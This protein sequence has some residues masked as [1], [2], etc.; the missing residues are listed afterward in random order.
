VTHSEVTALM[1]CIQDDSRNTLG[2]G[3][4]IWVVHLSVKSNRAITKTQIQSVYEY[5]AVKNT[6]PTNT[7]SNVAFKTMLFDYYRGDCI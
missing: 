1:P 3:V 2:F 5:Y 4:H 7:Y 6:T